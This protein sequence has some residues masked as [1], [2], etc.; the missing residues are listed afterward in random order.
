MRANVRLLEHLINYWDH[1]L[2]AFDLQGEILE[3]SVEDMYFI[4]GLSRRGIFV[5]LDGT[6]RGG[7]P[8]SVQDC[9]DTCCTPGTQKKGSSIPIFHITN[10]PL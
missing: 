2:G 4:I 7:D 1:D 9:V 3:V 5:N 10:F 8:M 6:G